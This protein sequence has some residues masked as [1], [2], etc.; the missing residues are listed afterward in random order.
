MQSTS[1]NHNR[2]FIRRGSVAAPLMVAAFTVEIAVSDL[3]K[4]WIWIRAFIIVP[5]ALMT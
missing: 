3:S 1:R 5:A 4:N 2:A